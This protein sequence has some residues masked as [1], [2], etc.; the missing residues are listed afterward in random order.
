MEELL[1]RIRTHLKIHFLSAELERKRNDQLQAEI[2]ERQRAE[3]EVRTLA[4]REAARWGLRHFWRRRG[5]ARGNRGDPEAA[6]GRVGARADHGGERDRQGMRWRAPSISRGRRPGRRLSRMN[7]SPSRQELAESSFF[8]HAKAPSPT[9]S[10]SSELLEQADG[11]IF[12]DEVGDLPL[13][14]PGKLLQVLKD[15]LGRARGS[16]RTSASRSAWCRRRTSI[17]RP[18]IKVEQVSGGLSG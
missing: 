5:P 1:S 18:E 6:P 15:G 12:L 14:L 2:V 8:G 17:C 13:A 7:C 9:P 11:G 10:M 4:R 3:A 16:A